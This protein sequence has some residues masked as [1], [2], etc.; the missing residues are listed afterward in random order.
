[1]SVQP[2]GLRIALGALLAFAALN[3]F[4]GGFYGLAGAEGV[5]VAW[6]EGTP[7]TSYRIP[8][9]ILFVVVG[10]AFLFAA[11]ATFANARFAREAATAAAIIVL[12]WIVV[13]VAMIGYVSWMQ[14]T[15]A[16]AGVVIL[17]LAWLSPRGGR[18]PR[19]ERTRR[20]RAEHAR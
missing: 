4:G 17:L 20:A 7:F 15:T 2:R 11:V 14:P 16:V 9:L 12:G 13:Q 10:G 19:C 1:M 18:T 6:L 3:A 5:P 8:S